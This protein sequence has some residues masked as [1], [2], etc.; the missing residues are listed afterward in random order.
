MESLLSKYINSEI[1]V[2]FSIGKVDTATLK[3]FDSGFIIIQSKETV[4]HIPFH[5]IIRFIEAGDEAYSLLRK[6]SFPLTIVV[7]PVMSVISTY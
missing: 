5:A 4:Q 7:T 3:S 2:S 6:R 1:G